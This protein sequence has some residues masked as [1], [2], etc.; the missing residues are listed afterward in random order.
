MSKIC[1][2]VA[3]LL[4]CE[5]EDEC[6]FLPSDFDVHDHHQYSLKQLVHKEMKLHEG[7]AHDALHNLHVAIKYGQTL[8]QHRKDH[9][10]KQGP[11]TCVK[12]IIFDARLKQS[13]QAEKYRAAHAAMVRLGHTD[14]TFPELKD[15][16]MYTKD[17]MAPHALGD[18]L[19]MEGWIWNVGPLGKMSET[20]YEDWTKEK[21]LEILE[22]EF[23]RTACAFDQMAFVWKELAGRHT[24][25][26]YMAYAHEKSAM[27]RD[28]AKECKDKF[29][30]AGG[31]WP[32]TGTSL[33]DHIH[34]ARKNLG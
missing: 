20:E 2:H 24:R 19:K 17:T 29:K 18:G 5:V 22:E 33:T 11:A 4:S 16:D 27:Y 3:A 25:R 15:G 31:T 8:N 28:M 34:R 6:L 26:G 14:N 21:E 7:Q 30:A 9:V 13:T 10:C 1:D 32:E 12:E 23:C